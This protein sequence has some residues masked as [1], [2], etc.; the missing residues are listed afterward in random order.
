MAPQPSNDN[1]IRVGGAAFSYKQENATLS[2][3]GPSANYGGG[4]GGGRMSDF[5]AKD[6]VDARID[7]ARANT[8]A[9][10]AEV[11]AKLE[12]LGTKMV[13]KRSLWEAVAVI[14]GIILAVL[15]F[16]GDRF[17][18]GV[19]VAQTSVETAFNAKQLSEENARQIKALT[20]AITK[21]DAQI[22]TL[23][24]LLKKQPGN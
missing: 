5:S 8:D 17:D 14:V 24:E 22:D 13:T 16:G 9:R 11:L 18:G 4:G 1:V 12:S 15:A 7:Q 2:E 20:E 3:S 21:R 19:Q 10:F 6:Y 23:I